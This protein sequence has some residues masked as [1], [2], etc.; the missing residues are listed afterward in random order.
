MKH[1]IAYETKNFFIVNVNRKVRT[2][3]LRLHN[4]NRTHSFLIGD[5]ENLDRL[6]KIADKMDQFPKSV[7][8]MR[9]INGDV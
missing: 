5:N 1:T 2:Y 9:M 4:K 8:H 7:E 6:K 3:E